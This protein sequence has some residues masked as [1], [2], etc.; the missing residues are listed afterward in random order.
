ME[1]QNR[2]RNIQIV[3]RVTPE[4]KALIYEKMRLCGMTNFQA[5]AR[6]MA[7]KGYIVDVDFTVLKNI[8]AEMQN[9]D[10]AAKKILRHVDT[11]GS[12]YAADA[13]YMRQKQADCWDLMRQLF[14]EAMK[15]SKA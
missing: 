9:I 4:E 5:Y 11:L 3:F 1:K 2:T 15:L 8:A 6:Q 14:K 10:V 12:L 7:T 13:A